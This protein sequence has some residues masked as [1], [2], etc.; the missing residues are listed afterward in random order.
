MS[1]SK[2]LLEYYQGDEFCANVWSDKYRVKGQWRVY[3]IIPQHGAFSGM[4]VT[5]HDMQH[6]MAEEF[7][8]I[9]KVYKGKDHLTSDDIFHMF[10]DFKYIIPQ[11]SIMAMLGNPD[12]IGS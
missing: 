5:P 1:M 10:K 12:Q 3:S 4:E 2:E 11:G 6:R 7:A 9:E 8:S